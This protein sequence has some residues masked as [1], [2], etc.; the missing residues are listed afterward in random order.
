MAIRVTSFLKR[1]HSSN[2]P[3]PSPPKMAKMAVMGGMVNFYKIWGEARNGEGGKVLKSLYT[4]G[5]GVLTKLFYEELPILPIPPFSNVV[6]L[7][8]HVTSN[9]PSTVPSVVMFL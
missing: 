4:V 3:S 9:P 7:N 1:D 5:R 6:Y 2:P 8:F